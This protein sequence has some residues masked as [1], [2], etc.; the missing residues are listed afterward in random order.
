MLERVDERRFI[1]DNDN[2]GSADKASLECS[3]SPPVT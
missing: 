2:L 3:Q 1:V